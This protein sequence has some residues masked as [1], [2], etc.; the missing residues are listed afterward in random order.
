M[1]HYLRPVARYTSNTILA[2][3]ASQLPGWPQAVQVAD[4][5]LHRLQ[6][7]HLDPEQSD[8]EADIERILTTGEVPDD[9]GQH[10]AR[11][12]AYIEDHQNQRTVLDDLAKRAVIQCESVISGAAPA[13]LTELNARVTATISEV[14]TLAQD[15]DGIQSADDAI[16]AGKKASDAWRQ[17]PTLRARYDALRTAQAVVMGQNYEGILESAR[18]TAD[19]DRLARDTDIANL[20]E[21]WPGWR[22]QAAS[23]VPRDFISGER[24]ILAPWPAD[25]LAQLVWLAT[26]DAK[27]WVPTKQQLVQLWE[28]RKR[29]DQEAIIAAR[30][31][32]R[33]GKPNPKPNPKRGVRMMPMMF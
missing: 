17:L 29:A 6:A 10:L 7:L 20:D 23:D 31:A 33:E 18:R 22:A 5:C 3:I 15:L 27:V 13:I 2:E 9:F 24:L 21:V 8:S 14:R 4:T 30:K 12:R 1:N 28:D 25:P 32:E 26:S 11:Q 19:N 16:T